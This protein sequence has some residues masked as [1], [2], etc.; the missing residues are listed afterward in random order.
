MKK[1][2]LLIPI[3]IALC[4]PNRSS[5][6]QDVFSESTDGLTNIG[7]APFNLTAPKFNCDGFIESLKPL[8]E[9]HIAFLYNT[10]GN[11]FSCLNR[12][13]AD[14]RLKT[15][16]VNLINEPGHR[17]NRLGTYEFL[18][19]VGSVNTWN[20]KLKNRDARLRQKYI[21]YVKPLQDGS[22]LKII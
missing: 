8:T 4:L 12:L 21:D 11:D 20:T 16:E 2:F 9:I 15:L 22:N 19:G 5:S 14:Q 1:I 17:N 6:S 13:L 3:L 18:Y 10:F 7:Y